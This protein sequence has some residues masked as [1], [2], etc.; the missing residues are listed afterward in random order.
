M[1]STGPRGYSGLA[2]VPGFTS[3]R[4][5]SVRRT[6]DEVRAMV[7]RTHYYLAIAADTLAAVGVQP[8]GP[9]PNEALSAPADDMSLQELLRIYR[10]LCD[11]HH[12]TLLLIKAWHQLPEDSDLYTDI[13]NELHGDRLSPDDAS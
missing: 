13:D 6:V 10:L 11:H 9:L 1:C 12:S 2:G 4:P 3:S 8:P 5:E 7:L